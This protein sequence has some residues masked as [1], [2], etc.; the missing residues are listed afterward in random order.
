MIKRRLEDQIRDRLQNSPSVALMGPRQVGKTTLAF[1][2]SEGVPSVYLDLENR[3]D[4]QKVQDIGAFHRANNDKLIILDEVHRL[5][6]VFAPIR[7][8][9]DAERAS[10][11][12]SCRFLK[13]SIVS[14]HS[15][16]PSF[17]LGNGVFA[18]QHLRLEKF[19]EA[20]IHIHLPQPGGSDVG[21]VLVGGATFPWIAL[22]P[23]RRI[24]LHQRGFARRNFPAVEGPEV[25]PLTELIAQ[26]TKP[27]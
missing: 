10:F 20:A 7:G 21:I 18:W 26:I 17:D 12:G 11:L 15:E 8:L 1:H 19:A 13:K 9:I 14:H 4:L 24:D 22:A 2:I 23:Q 5:P 3:T 16:N 6:E 25:D 27:G